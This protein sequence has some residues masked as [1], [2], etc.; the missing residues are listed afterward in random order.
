M[1]DDLDNSTK[2]KELVIYNFTIKIKFT[3]IK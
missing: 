1:S 2:I 3:I